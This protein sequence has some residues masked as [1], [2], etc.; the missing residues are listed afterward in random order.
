M[1]AS[2]SGFS[3]LR[4]S[5]PAIHPYGLVIRESVSRFRYGGRHI[6]LE[7]PACA[8]I[9]A[10]KDTATERHARPENVVIGSL[11]PSF[12]CPHRRES[13]CLLQHS[14]CS[15]LLFIWG[16]AVLAQ[17]TLDEHTELCANIFA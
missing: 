15:L 10:L 9:T 4:Y 12:C 11:P 6:M 17:D 2:S 13:L 1:T 14:F 7:S 5:L 8:T 16:I 3:V